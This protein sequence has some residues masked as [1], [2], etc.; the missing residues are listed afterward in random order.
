MIE[1]GLF[2][3]TIFI[4]I[5]ELSENI[6]IKTNFCYMR[7]ACLGSIPSLLSMNSASK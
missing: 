5:T 1:Y 6:V 7:I 2:N 4:K 3:L